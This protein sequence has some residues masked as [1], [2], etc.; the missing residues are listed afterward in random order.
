MNIYPPGTRISQYEIV[1]HP[2]MGGMGIVYL[3]C[4]D[5]EGNRPVALKTFC[6]QFLGS[7][8][9]THFRQEVLPW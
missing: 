6:R 3:C 8:A 7:I 1:S 4:L 9:V 5:H 2:L